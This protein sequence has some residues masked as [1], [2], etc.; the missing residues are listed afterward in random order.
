M[1]EVK[2]K[3]GFTSQECLVL[4]IIL[5]QQRMTLKRTILM[6]NKQRNTWKLS[7][8]WHSGS[9]IILQNDGSILLH[10]CPVT[11]PEVRIIYGENVTIASLCHQV[12]DWLLPT[13][14]HSH[15]T[16]KLTFQIVTYSHFYVH[17][18]QHLHCFLSL[19]HFHISEPFGLKK[20]SN[21]MAAELSLD[22]VLP[23]F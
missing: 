11:S 17:H 14:T 10:W 21:A 1:V 22:S 3:D 6:L 19:V 15:F 7:K 16:F 5:T 20:F 8:E 23:A 4:G 12:I 18:D 2:V 9:V 13:T